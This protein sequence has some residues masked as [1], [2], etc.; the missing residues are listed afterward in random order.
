MI[1]T[2]L[3]ANIVIQI[4]D[5]LFRKKVTSIIERTFKS[6]DDYGV[7]LRLKTILFERTPYAVIAT[8]EMG[9]I[10]MW[11]TRAEVKFGWKQEEVLGK[12]ITII[13]PEEFRPM[14]ELGMKAWRDTGTSR[15]I[16]NEDGV[17]LM[18]QNKAGT[19]FPIHLKLISVNDKGFKTVGGFVRNITKEVEARTILM[20][21]LDFTKETLQ[22]AEIGGWDWSLDTGKVIIDD[23]AKKLFNVPKGDE[24]TA[25]MLVNLV[26]PRDQ[27][28]VAI[29]INRSREVKEDY[30]VYYR[31]L[32]ADGSLI[33][34][35]CH[36]YMILDNNDSVSHI[37]GTVRNV[38]IAND[39]DEDY[40]G[41][42]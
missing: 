33:W 38:G 15:I 27:L 11:N 13:I 4:L 31:R 26:L 20:E 37:R 34:I 14:H 1:E 42:S 41:H 21:D 3:I 22:L 16:D 32:Q 29:A 18:G 30:V 10:L 39:K 17:E 9:K 19:K 28:K 7:N 23:I 35:E 2:L 24:V 40:N 5:I 8:D 12:P 36:G 6:D 25:P